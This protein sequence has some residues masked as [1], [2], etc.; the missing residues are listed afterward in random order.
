M[1]GDHC[2]LASGVKLGGQVTIDPYCFVGTGAV[3]RNKV[4]LAE[5]TVIGA[6]AVVTQ[7]TTAGGIYL[8]PAAEKMPLD[9]S[10]LFGCE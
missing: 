10:Q 5:R 7:N 3:I 9:S 2:F 1:I 8:A 6:G 4:T